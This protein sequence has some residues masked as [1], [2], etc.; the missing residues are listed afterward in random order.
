MFIGL[1]E[2]PLAKLTDELILFFLVD[3]EHRGRS[4]HHSWLGRALAVFGRYQRSRCDILV[5]Q[6]DFTAT[7]VGKRWHV[8]PEPQQLHVELQSARDNPQRF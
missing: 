5:E 4:E 1:A 8:D 7:S 6:Q 3:E 2:L